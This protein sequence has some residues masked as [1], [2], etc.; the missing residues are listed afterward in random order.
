MNYKISHPNN[1]INCEINL[2]SSKSISNRLLIIKALSNKAITINDISNSEDTINLKKG[3]YSTS[4][5]ID[6]NHSGTAFRFLTSYLSSIKNKEY[7]LTG[8]KRIQQRPI[9]ELVDI[10]DQMGANI[11]YMD[12]KGFAPLK[13]KGRKLKGGS[14]QISGKISSQ[15]ITSILLI[16]PTLDNGIKLQ[17]DSSLVSAPYVYMTLKIM[18]EFGV[19][20]EWKDNT[21]HIKKQCYQS[22]VTFVESDWSAASFWFQIAALSS[23]CNIILNGLEER[24]IQGDK[25]CKYFFD[26][27]GVS[28]KFL[29]KSLILTKNKKVDANLNYDLIK[30]PD[31]FQPLACTHFAKNIKAKFS[32]TDSLKIKE[33]NRLQA[34]RN[35]LQKLNTNKIIDTYN[36]HRMAMSFAPLCLSHGEIQINNIEVVK[37][38]YPKF[39]I[40]L[41][42]AG[43]KIS[44]IID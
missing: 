33:S 19:E 6:I 20:S 34:V 28:S 10:L 26:K 14:Y 35:E 37:K 2:P 44:P 18:K 8:S 27:L 15:F 40:D 9:K 39:W 38:S 30:Y 16:A 11:N 21:I 17:I 3:I 32:G 36:D 24:S 41:K 12:K 4:K 13:I 5:N 7:I 22:K 42:K 23:N 31:L 25:K 1:I 43:F 29:N